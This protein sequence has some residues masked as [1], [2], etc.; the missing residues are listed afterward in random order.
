M[1]D[2]KKKVPWTCLIEDLKMSVITR[3]LKGFNINIRLN[4]STTLLPRLHSLAYKVV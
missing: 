4:K 1:K 2:V 3:T